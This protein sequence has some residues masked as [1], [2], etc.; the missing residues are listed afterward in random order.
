LPVRDVLEGIRDGFLFTPLYLPIAI[1]YAI[2]AQAMGLADWQIVLWSA[3]IFAG[4]AQLACLSALATGAGL[5]ELLVITFMAN[6]RHSFVAMVI[7]PYYYSR[8]PPRWLPV[9]A[10]TSSVGAMALLPRR[11]A[12][13]LFAYGLATQMCQWCIWV[14]GAALGVWIGPLIPSA[15]APVIGFAAPAAFIGLLNPMVREN[16]ASGLVVVTVAAALGLGLTV[17]WPPQICAIVGAIGG[18]LASL[19]VPERRRRDHAR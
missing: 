10:F 5:V 17:I 15:W 18:S 12:G 8:V 2:A 19:L 9:L 4:S 11:K 7:A 6:A 13:S 3:L 14:G 16:L 1:P